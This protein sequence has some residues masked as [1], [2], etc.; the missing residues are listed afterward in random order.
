MSTI[1]AD[2]YR[3]IQ[4]LDKDERNKRIQKDIEMLARHVDF[5]N[6]QSKQDIKDHV[7]QLVRQ[8]FRTAEMNKVTEIFREIDFA[9][10]VAIN[11]L[12]QYH[13]TDERQ[14]LGAQVEVT[15]EYK[16]GKLDPK[17]IVKP[18]RKKN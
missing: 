13:Q 12:F 3:K 9:E 17:N 10:P 1:Y 6:M 5:I 8:D 11:G 14:K 16:E 2:R 18:R 4:G 7:N 15:K